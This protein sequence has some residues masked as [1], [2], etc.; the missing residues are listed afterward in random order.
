M[1]DPIVETALKDLAAEL[2]VEVSAR[3]P[4]KV[5]MAV[6]VEPRRSPLWIWGLAC[7]AAAVVAGRR[8][9]R[10]RPTSRRVVRRCPPPSRT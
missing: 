7:H 10:R 2:D 1:T 6:A 3:F 5:R 8:A 4:A 9:A